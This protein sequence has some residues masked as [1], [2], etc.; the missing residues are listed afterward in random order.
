MKICQTGCSISDA[1]ISHAAALLNR[2]GT[3]IVVT[4]EAELIGIW[5]DLDSAEVRAAIA[6][7]GRG[8]LPVCYLDSPACPDHYKVRH[9][10]GEPVPLSVLKAMEQ[11]SEPWKVWDQLL[12]RKR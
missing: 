11:A 8:H 12:R 7:V 9:V 1:E 2:A 10:P 4:T 3:R 6:M 5:S